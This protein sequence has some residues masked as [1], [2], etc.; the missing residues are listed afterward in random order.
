MKAKSPPYLV[1]LLVQ[2]SAWHVRLVTASTTI[3]SS[4]IISG[5]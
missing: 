2:G 3:P 4:R 5:M 1:E